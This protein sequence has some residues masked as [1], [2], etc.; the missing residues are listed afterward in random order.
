MKTTSDKISKAEN[1]EHENLNRGMKTRQM[2]MMAIGGAIGVGLF[3]GSSGAI[4]YAGPS[5]LLAYIIAGAAM[6]CIVRAVGEMATAEPVSGATVS[7][8]SRYI[9]PFMGFAIGWTGLLGSVAGSGAEFTA[10]GEYVKY[11]FP[12]I[13]IWVS[14]LVGV[15]FTALINLIS[16]A[17]FGES[18][19]W[20]SMVKVVTIVIMVVGG[21]FII[22]TGVGT[23][24]HPILFKNLTVDGFMPNGITGLLFSLVLVAFAFGGV[25]SVVYTAGEAKNVKTTMP[26]AVNGVFWSILLF[27]V[28]STFVILC[29]WPW[30]KL[31]G[32]GSPFVKV[33]AS[34]GIPAAADVIN[35]VV[36]TASLSALS[37]G[38]YTFSRQLYNLSLQGS[39]PKPLSKVSSKKIPYISVITVVL[40][41]GIGI[42]LMAVL[43]ARAFSIFS[44]ITVFMLVLSWVSELLA[45]LRFRKI[46]R[47]EGRES[48]LTF[49][50]PFYP[51]ADYF[52]LIIMGLVMIMMAIMPAY[53]VSYLVT[54]PWMILLFVIYQ[55]QQKKKASGSQQG[56]NE[57]PAESAAS[58]SSA[59][60]SHEADDS[61][62]S[63]DTEGATQSSSSS[64]KH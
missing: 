11:W 17:F 3:Y 52:A 20:L 41:Q 32:V 21:L 23:G 56:L 19:F 22:F 44:S 25:E 62:A 39:A 57:A 45:H 58:I 18:Q 63:S 31:Q 54:I 35:F 42:V 46:R 64:A 61:K 55:V 60:I 6:F 33:F 50:Q 38:I 28:G 40:M 14:A 10:L 53:R 47:D 9:H 48:E 16:V 49:K 7:Y 24:G 5:V 26:K 13:P 30:D 43:P 51:F 4:T 37:S 15:A 29:M 12:G 36:I 2:Q 8:A 34:L 59:A 1:Y 27:Y